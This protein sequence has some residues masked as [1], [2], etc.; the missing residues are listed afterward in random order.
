MLIFEFEKA[1]MKD[2][3]AYSLDQALHSCVI[4]TIKNYLMAFCKE[5]TGTDDLSVLETILKVTFKL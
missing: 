5:N 4:S 2:D 1:L 3:M